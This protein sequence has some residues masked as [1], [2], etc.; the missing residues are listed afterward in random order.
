MAGPAF[1]SQ[2][3]QSL[4]AFFGQKIRADLVSS[5]PNPAFLYI[6]FILTYYC[7]FPVEN[8]V[9]TR[10]LEVFLF[11]RRVTVPEV[12]VVPPSMEN[13]VSTAPPV[14]LIAL[15]STGAGKI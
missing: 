10:V 13:T 6:N 12:V 7:T 1:V 14:K 2:K 8:I 5:S 3:A 11:E 4:Q 15:I 9:I